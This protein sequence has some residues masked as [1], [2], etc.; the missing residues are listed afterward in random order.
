MKTIKNVRKGEI[1]MQEKSVLELLEAIRLEE[2]IYV[3]D[4]AKWQSFLISLMITLMK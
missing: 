4:D 2:E 3:N 1:K